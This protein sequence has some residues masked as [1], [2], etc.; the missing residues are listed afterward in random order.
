MFS[1]NE[2]GVIQIVG[3]E[4]ES[5]QNSDQIVR[6]ATISIIGFIQDRGKIRENIALLIETILKTI[7][8]SNES[9]PLEDFGRYGKMSI[10]TVEDHLE[11]TKKTREL[12]AAG[13]NISFSWA[14]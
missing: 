6:E 3:N 4:I 5:D 1:Q 13:L 11:D 14:E 12:Y 9:G 2:F 8:E 10:E 7:K